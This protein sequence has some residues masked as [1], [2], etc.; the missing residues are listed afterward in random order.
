MGPTWLDSTQHERPYQDKGN[1]DFGEAHGISRTGSV[2]E[3]IL[4]H[5]VDVKNPHPVCRHKVVVLACPQ[6]EGYEVENQKGG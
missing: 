4:R 6:S 3:T 1:D 5:T 2:G